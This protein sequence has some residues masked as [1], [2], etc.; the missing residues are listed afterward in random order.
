MRSRFLLHLGSDVGYVRLSGSKGLPI[1]NSA[2]LQHL[3]TLRRPQG[4]GAPWQQAHLHL[5]QYGPAMAASSVHAGWV[6]K[7]AGLLPTQEASLSGW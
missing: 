3:T 4:Q 2:A 5:W 7:G 6:H 1:V